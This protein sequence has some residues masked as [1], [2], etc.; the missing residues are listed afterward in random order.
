ML[1]CRLKDWA[2]TEFPFLSISHKLSVDLR[3][4]NPMSTIVFA[5]FLLLRLILPV[6]F[7]LAVGEWIRRREVNYWFHS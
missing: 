6:S 4:E 5:A 7:L 3:K 2:Y 1:T